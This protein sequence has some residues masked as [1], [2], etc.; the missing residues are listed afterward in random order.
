MSKVTITDKNSVGE[1]V[2]VYVKKPNVQQLSESK[3]IKNRSFADGLKKGS[4]L[5]AS[6]R[7]KMKEQGVWNDDLQKEL[8][9]VTFKLL[10]GEAQ[11]KR[12]GRTKTGD[13]FT[14]TQARKLAIEMMD[15][16]SRFLEL[17]SLM[18]TYDQFTVEAVAE[19]DEFDY[20]CSVCIMD[21]DGE[22]NFKDMEDF[23]EKSEEPYVVKAVT[24]LAKLV[25]EYDDDWFKKLPEMDFL[26][27][28][29]F[30]NNDLQFILNGELVDKDGK[31]IDEF[32]RYLVEGRTT[33]EFGDN[34]DEK[35]NIVDFVEFE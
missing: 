30:M 16:R 19:A 2:T 3:L 5:R 1:D 29:G 6:V 9:V 8:D 26:I 18:S 21:E 34:V 15:L 33:N 4:V 28:Y 23:K 12:G 13:K 20:L 31:R 32:G 10:E 24:E 22:S 25:Y 14:R 11:L 35:G 27:K 17:R 7:S